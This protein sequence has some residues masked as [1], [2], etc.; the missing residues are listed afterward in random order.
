MKLAC[1][2]YGYRSPGEPVILLLTHDCE[3][4]QRI[5]IWESFNAS[6]TKVV[7]LLK[8]WQPCK[9]EPAVIGGNYVPAVINHQLCSL[10]RSS[11]SCSN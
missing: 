7:K 3:K 10:Q 1:L 2:V 6:D 5:R 11:C 4:W 8:L 9:I